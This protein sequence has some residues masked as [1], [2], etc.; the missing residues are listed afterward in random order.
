MPDRLSHLRSWRSAFAALV[1]ACTVMLP[2][3][4]AAEALPAVADPE[5]ERRMLQITA[6]L[7]CLVCQN[8]TVADS[9]AG[10]ADDLRQQV[11][12]ML[13]KGASNE[14][15]IAFMTAR[16]G[17]FVLY[18][19]PVKPTTVLL[20]VGPAVLMVGG[21]VAL[22]VVLRRRSRMP[23]EAFEPD[24]DDLAEAARAAAGADPAE[25]SAA[26]AATPRA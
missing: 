17:D 8:Q 7:R 15:I 19:P 20:W 14:E 18:R 6:E 11:R 23:A 26:A 24:E 4:R 5:L 16:Y 2:A 12:E 9:H 25:A 3:A 22:I 10:L 21:L 1:L 13:H